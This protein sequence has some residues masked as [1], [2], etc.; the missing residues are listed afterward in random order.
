M[1]AGQLQRLLENN[2]FAAQLTEGQAKALAK[3]IEKKIAY[4]A[5][6]DAL[7]GLPNRLQLNET[8]SL[9][10]INATNRGNGIA[11][12]FIDLDLFKHVNDALGHHT[13]DQLLQQRGHLQV[14]GVPGRILVG[15]NVSFDRR[16]LRQAFERAALEMVQAADAQA[17][18]GVQTRNRVGL[19]TGRVVADL[20]SGRA[21]EK[22]PTDDPWRTG[23]RPRRPILHR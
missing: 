2:G 8:L 11:V 17:F 16:V 12:L 23:H 18:A 13:G 4:M 7:T 20:A 3:A 9:L 21:S 22:N 5:H 14:V 19:A 10:I 6:H 15:H 1:A